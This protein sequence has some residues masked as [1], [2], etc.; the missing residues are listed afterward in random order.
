ME[1]TWIE[2]RCESIDPGLFDGAKMEV[3]QKNRDLDAAQ[4]GHGLMLN[5]S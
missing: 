5:A 4:A 1:A 3:R 2:V